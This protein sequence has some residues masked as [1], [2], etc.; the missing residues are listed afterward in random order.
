MIYVFPSKYIVKLSHVKGKVNL[1]YE[2]IQYG[3]IDIAELNELR[4][5]FRRSLRTYDIYC[6]Y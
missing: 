4:M 6:C 5:L 1:E 3:F 2:K